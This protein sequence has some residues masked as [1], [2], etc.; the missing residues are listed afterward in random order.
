MFLWYENSGSTGQNA[1]FLLQLPAFPEQ[2]TCSFQDC[3]VPCPTP[4][5]GKHF[6]LKS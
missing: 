1:V 5:L 4:V 6:V 2:G 3:N